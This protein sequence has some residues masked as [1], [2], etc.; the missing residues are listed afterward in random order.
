MT[1]FIIEYNE[2]MTFNTI[3]MHHFNIKSKK[4]VKVYT[5]KHVLVEKYSVKSK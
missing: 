1:L 5:L 3:K 2:V 4:N